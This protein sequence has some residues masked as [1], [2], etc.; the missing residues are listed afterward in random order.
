MVTGVAVLWDPIAHIA[1]HL[2][3]FHHEN[4]QTSRPLQGVAPGPVSAPC[5]ASAPSPSCQGQPP[6]E[7][8]VPE[9]EFK[10]ATLLE[11]T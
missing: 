3:I 5:W 6:Q 2:L 11:E 7:A 10:N 9:P 4:P 8:I 1:L